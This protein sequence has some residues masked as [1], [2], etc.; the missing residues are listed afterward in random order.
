MKVVY[1]TQIRILQFGVFGLLG[2]Q[3]WTQHF[4]L[5]ELG[6]IFQALATKDYLLFSTQDCDHINRDLFLFFFIG[7]GTQVVGGNIADLKIFET[8]T[9]LL[10]QVRCIGPLDTSQTCV[11]VKS[12]FYRKTLTSS[13][14]KSYSQSPRGQNKIYNFYGQPR[15]ARQALLEISTPNIKKDQNMCCNS[16]T[17]QIHS[18]F[19]ENLHMNHSF[20]KT[21][22]RNYE[23]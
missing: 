22:F 12:Q 15:F 16:L 4:G 3:K 11:R 18:E 7:P 17:S 6:L 20:N 14:L 13:R 5:F 8:K 9:Q 21:K 2:P 23:Y 1:A 19:N 10:C